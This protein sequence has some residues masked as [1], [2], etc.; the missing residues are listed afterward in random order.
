MPPNMLS[1]FLIHT[2]PRKSHMADVINELASRYFISETTQ[3][4]IHD[5]PLNTEW[6]LQC[7]MT[8]AGTLDPVDALNRGAT[9]ADLKYFST[10]LGEHHIINPPYQ[11]T[12]SADI[13]ARGIRKNAE[14]PSVMTPKD[15][16]IGMGRGY[17]MM[18]D[19]NHQ[20]V[21][22]QFGTT[23]YNSLMQFFT[24]FYDSG[25]ALLARTGRAGESFVTKVFRITGNAAG[26]LIAPL[27]ILPWA[28]MMAAQAARYFMRW[29]ASRFCYL[30]PDMPLYWNAVT[31]MV[32]QL[33]VYNGTINYNRPEVTEQILGKEQ[34]LGAGAVSMLSQFIPEMTSDGFID[35]YKVSTKAKRRQ[36]RHEIALRKRYE[37]LSNMND[38]NA[39]FGMVRKFITTELGE[40]I[41]QPSPNEPR[42]LSLESKLLDYFDRLSVWSSIT[43]SVRGM[44]AHVE[45][46]DR[47]SSSPMAVKNDKDPNGDP[48][49]QP[50]AA[51]ARDESFFNYWLADDADGAAWLSLAVHYTGQVQDSFSSSVADNTLGETINSA[52]GTA[53]NMRVNLA[54]GN[55]DSAG[56]TQMVTDGVRAILTNVADT[57]MISGIATMAGSA[58]VDIPKHW[59]SA[60]ATL[61]RQTY[62][63]HLHT[64]YNNPVSRAMDIFIPLACILC[65]GLPIKA[66]AQAYTAPFYCQF[67]DRGRMMSRY[68][69]I[70]S[71][72][73]SRG[74]TNLGYTQE[75]HALGFEVSFEVTDLS[76]IMAIPIQPGF[77]IFKGVFDAEDALSDWMMGASGMPLR[78]IV[79]RLPMLEYQFRRKRAEF[80]TFTSPAY[81]ASEMSTGIPNR[82][83]SA[84]LRGTDRQ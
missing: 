51:P 37:A 62:T 13:P 3:V 10:N 28:I 6:I 1:Y 7:F 2:L 71:I 14:R 74:T 54:D 8:Q 69:I 61:P 59:V 57:L 76:S 11:F 50:Y 77:S 46:N 31:N 42:G 21:H 18:I 53:R 66:G 27:M 45:G 19:E 26:L 15:L 36:M 17:D 43:D 63:L 29:P 49:I 55:I 82:I 23:S 83:F 48:I 16:N 34:K 75:G 78:D 30:K 84:L 40:T 35:M 70:T 56:I 80:D 33:L 32:N 24:G 79:N 39:W 81:W 41:E 12:P 20:I 38:P 47:V 68:A 67:F 44:I 64:P 22:F 9:T 73:I 5:L 4:E 72:S 65:G 60:S 58:F 52:S 25:A